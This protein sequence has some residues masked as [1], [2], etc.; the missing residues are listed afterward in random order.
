MHEPLWRGTRKFCEMDGEAS[1]NNSHRYQTPGV[2]CYPPFNSPQAGGHWTL[3]HN[4]TE[5]LDT[6]SLPTNDIS[7]QT[8]KKEESQSPELR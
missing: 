8:P 5:E 3:M 2:L 7:D 1:I 4:D 6:L